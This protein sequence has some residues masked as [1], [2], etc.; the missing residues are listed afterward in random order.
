V[1]RYRC[2]DAE[3]AA[4]FSVV[5]A[6]RAAGVTR[7]AF[8]A[9][10]AKGKPG[11]RTAE[12]AEAALVAEIGTI[13]RQSSGTYGSPRVHAAGAGSAGT[14]STGCT[15]QRLPTAREWEQQHR[16][17]HPLPSPLAA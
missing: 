10:A 7:S 6:C 16:H 8:Y 13:H 11:P 9:W 15:P 1:S 3:K 12:Q 17:D 5:A 2:V 4:G 14:T